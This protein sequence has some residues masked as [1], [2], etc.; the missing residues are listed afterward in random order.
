MSQNRENYFK[1]EI[2]KNVLLISKILK[3]NLRFLRVFL[4]LTKKNANCWMLESQILS[5]LKFKFLRIV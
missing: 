3:L 2:P 5:A 4:P 1:I